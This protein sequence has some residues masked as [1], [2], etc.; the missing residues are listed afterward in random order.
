MLDANM[1]LKTQYRP[2]LSNINK[3]LQSYNQAHL[4]H[5]YSVCNHRTA[6]SYFFRDGRRYQTR[7]TLVVY[8]ACRHIENT[9]VKIVLQW[10]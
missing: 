3:I 4:S 10:Q 2:Q 9:L 7:I 5:L 8:T 6:T 1:S